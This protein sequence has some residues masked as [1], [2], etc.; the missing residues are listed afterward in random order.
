MK[1]MFITIALLVCMT[2]LLAGCGGSGAKKPDRHSLFSITEST[3]I[4]M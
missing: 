2:G 4:R 3:W 1:K